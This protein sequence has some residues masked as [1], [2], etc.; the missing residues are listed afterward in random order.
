MPDYTRIGLATKLKDR[1]NESGAAIEGVG[2]H[3]MHRSHCSPVLTVD[4]GG[5]T[6]SE[7]ND[8]PLKSDGYPFH[9]HHSNHSSSKL[10]DGEVLETAE[11]P[12]SR[13]ADT[14]DDYLHESRRS[15]I[16]VDQHPGPLAHKSLKPP[17]IAETQPSESE[18][19]F[20]QELDQLLPTE[21]ARSAYDTHMYRGPYRDPTGF[22]DNNRK[23]DTKGEFRN[24]DELSNR[25]HG[26]R[27]ISN[28]AFT[29]VRTSGAS[30]RH[31][32]LMTLTNRI[33]KRDS[34]KIQEEDYAKRR[35]IHESDRS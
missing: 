21:S 23:D 12:I 15:L 28:E 34:N 16:R 9:D 3:N 19:D 18:V 26:N 6:A 4:Y 7:A 24:V 17:V 11:A 14:A 8:P 1:A 13:Q 2:E 10:E 30:N 29:T 25:S 32:V 33:R 20:Y 35:K 27:K 5:I 22:Y 31:Q